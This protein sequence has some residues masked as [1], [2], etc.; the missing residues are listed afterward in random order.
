MLGY[1]FSRSFNA[2]SARY[3]KQ[4]YQDWAEAHVRNAEWF[5]VRLFLGRGQY[6]TRTAKT[7]KEAR[8]VK[9]DM[10]AE[11]E[12]KGPT[13]GRKPMIYAVTKGINLTI[14]VE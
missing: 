4:L 14:H 2:L 10:M 6:D 8:Q 7:L 11:W 9:R 5:V 13:Y 3:N 12:A 1:N